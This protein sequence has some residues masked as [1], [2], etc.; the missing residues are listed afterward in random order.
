[1]HRQESWEQ[2]RLPNLLLA[3]V[4]GPRRLNVLTRLVALTK[5]RAE[6][7]CCEEQDNLALC[8]AGKSARDTQNF[9][10]D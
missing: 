10:K 4:F 9:S 1:M 8:H 7:S 6:Q 3:G 5:D 2:G